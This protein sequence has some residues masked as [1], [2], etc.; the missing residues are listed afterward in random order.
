MYK[1]VIHIF[2][3]KILVFYENSSIFDNPNG[4]HRSSRI[5]FYYLPILVSILH[6]QYHGATP[7]DVP[8]NGSPLSKNIVKH[9]F[10]RG[11]KTHVAKL[12]ITFYVFT[13]IK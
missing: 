6:T 8:A 7:V 9:R 2:Q 3:R 12:K 5:I 13:A 1:C 11:E 4:F 10:T